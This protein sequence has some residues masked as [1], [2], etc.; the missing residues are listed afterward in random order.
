MGNR[1]MIVDDSMFIWEEM[2]HLLA[3]SEFE[4]CGYAKTGEEAVSLY[5]ELMPDL[6]TMD[7]I[8]PGIDGIDSSKLILEKWPDA[9]IIIVSSLAYDETIEDARQIG[10]YSFIFKP[11]DKEQLFGALRSTLQG[12]RAFK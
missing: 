3:D 9:K 5:G 2:K 10:A 1:L 11:F 7:I 8:L 4:I 12:S 6:V